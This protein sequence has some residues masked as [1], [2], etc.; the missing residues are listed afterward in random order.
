MCKMSVEN[1]PVG[2]G[3]PTGPNVIMGKIIKIN[4]MAYKKNLSLGNRK[5]IQT[6]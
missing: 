3:L 4:T 1:M 6:T 2:S 5:N